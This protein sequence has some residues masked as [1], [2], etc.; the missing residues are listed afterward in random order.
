M[1]REGSRRGESERGGR[2]TGSEGVAQGRVSCVLRTRDE[3]GF[4][5]GIQAGGRDGTNGV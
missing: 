1:G 5:R 3:S 2:G 4:F